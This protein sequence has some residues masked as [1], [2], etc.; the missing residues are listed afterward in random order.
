MLNIEP[1]VKDVREAHVVFN[2]DKGGSRFDKSLP[3]R[4][5]SP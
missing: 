2:A 1:F 3:S 4:Q 5:P